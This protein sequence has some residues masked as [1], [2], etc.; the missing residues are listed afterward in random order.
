MKNY[1]SDWI[2]FQNEP[3]DVLF[4]IDTNQQQYLQELKTGVDAKKREIQKE[5]A[6]ELIRAA[7]DATMKD[8]S[9]H[10]SGDQKHINN[11]TGLDCSP[12]LLKQA[13]INMKV[14]VQIVY[15]PAKGVDFEHLFLYNNQIWPTTLKYLPVTQQYGKSGYG[16]YTFHTTRAV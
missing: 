16:P 11:V 14:V 2:Y 4:I 12:L 15:E 6:S 3:E 5:E 10:I 8:V 13:L 7:Y 9:S 1:K